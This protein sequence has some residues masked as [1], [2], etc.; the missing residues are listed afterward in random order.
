[1]KKALTAHKKLGNRGENIAAKELKILGMDILLMNFTVHKVGEIDIIGRDGR[2][3]CFVEVKTRKYSWRSRPSEAVN[4]QKKIKLWKTALHYLQT[5]HRP[6]MLF[7][8]DTV[9]I[10]VDS[11]YRFQSFNH[12]PASFTEEDVRQAQKLYYLN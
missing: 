12:I 1:M 6:H 7:R 9:E 4:W 11:Q 3:L 5:I 10:I 8:F 2:C